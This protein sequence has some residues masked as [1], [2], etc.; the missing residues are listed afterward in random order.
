LDTSSDE[1]DDGEDMT[2][3]DD[4]EEEDKKLEKEGIYMYVM[5]PFNK[6]GLSISSL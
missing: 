3:E 6:N 2:E 4:N 5:Q 1:E